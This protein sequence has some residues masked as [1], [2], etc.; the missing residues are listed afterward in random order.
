M[1]SMDINKILNMLPHRYPFA[2]ID[3]VLDY[4]AYDY[5][6]AVKN[7]TI[8]EPFFQGHFPGNPIM[9]GVLILEGMAQAGGILANVSRE[10]REGHTFFHYFAGIDEAKFKQVVIPGDQ[11]IFQLKL[12][13]QKR[14]FWK[15]RAEAYVGDKL[16]CSAFLMSAAKEVKSDQ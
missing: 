2:L 9:P 13:S 6:N 10:A 15:V 12:V 7:V 16:A 5:L 8:N 11:L 14:D 3:K 1:N 4:K